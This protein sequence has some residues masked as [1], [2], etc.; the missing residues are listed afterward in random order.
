MLAGGWLLRVSRMG[1]ARV[2]Y[3]SLCAKGGENTIRARAGNGGRPPR[4]TGMTFAQYW[5]TI[6]KPCIMRVQ[7]QERSPC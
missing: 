5:S 3:G 1:F 7:N 4:A 6:P 2:N